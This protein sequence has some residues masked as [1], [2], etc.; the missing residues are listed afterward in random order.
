M[1]E[2]RPFGKY[3]ESPIPK[4]KPLDNQENGSVGYGEINH[5]VCSDREFNSTVVYAEGSERMVVVLAA[6]TRPVRPFPTDLLTTNSPKFQG[7]WAAPAPTV[8]FV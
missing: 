7:P 1:G 8:L 2:T 4:R 5:E 6:P 3:G